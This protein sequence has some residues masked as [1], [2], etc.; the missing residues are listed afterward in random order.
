[1]DRIEIRPQS[2]KTD[3]VAVRIATSA[4]R[5]SAPRPFYEK[6]R[7]PRAARRPRGAE[8]TAAAAGRPWSSACC[9][10]VAAAAHEGLALLLSWASRRRRLRRGHHLEG[11]LGFGPGAAKMKKLS[12]QPASSMA[13][14]VPWTRGRPRSC[15]SIRPTSS[16]SA[17]PAACGAS[18]LK[19]HAAGLAAARARLSPRRRQ[20]P[21]NRA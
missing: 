13:A 12:I 14:W 15:C 4:D 20:G 21:R 6:S 10:S 7:R 11:I 8:L 17:A 19:L 1:M 3:R 5:G 18:L 9:C 2:T 16:R